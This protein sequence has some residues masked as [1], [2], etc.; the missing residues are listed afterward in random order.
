MNT[1]KYKLFVVIL[2]LF[3]STVEAQSVIQDWTGIPTPETFNVVTWNIEH[4]GREGQGPDDIEKQYANV[5]TVI[6]SLQADIIGLQEMYNIPLFEQLVEDLK[7]Y[8]GFITDYTASSLQVAFLYRID[9]IEFLDSRLL[10]AEFG[11]SDFD[12]NRRPPLEFTFRVKI[13]E[14]SDTMH[15]VTYHARHDTDNESYNRRLNASESLKAYFDEHR[16]GHALVF[17]GDFND[18]VIKAPRGFRYPPPYTPY[19]NFVED[20]SYAVVTKPLSYAGGMTHERGMMIDHIVVN[21]H[22][23]NLWMR[24]SEKVHLPFYIDDYFNTT[25]DHLPVIARFDLTGELEPQGERIVVVEPDNYPEEIGNLN[26]VIEEE[27]GRDPETIFELRRDVVY[28]TDRSIENNGFHLHLR[29]QKGSGKP[30]VIRPGINQSGTSDHLF[31][32]N[33]DV[34]FEGVFLVPVD[35]EGMLR[36]PLVHQSSGNTIRFLDGYIIGSYDI[37]FWFSCGSGNSL[38]I[39]NSIFANAGRNDSRNQGRFIDTRGYDQDTIWVEHSTIYN[40]QHSI[41]RNPGG[42]VN[43][44]HYNHNTIFNVAQY[45]RLGRVVHA[46]VTNNLMINLYTIGLHV[47]SNGGIIEFAP[48]GVL[49]MTEADRRFNIS[50]N[51]IGHVTDDVFEAML[52]ARIRNSARNMTKAPIVDEFF[53]SMKDPG[54]G[55]KITFRN[56]FEENVIFAD[57]PKSF[58]EWTEFWIDSGSNGNVVPADYP[59]GYDRWD[60]AAE[61]I[62]PSAYHY[63]IDLVRDFSYSSSHRSYTAAESGFPVGDLNWFPEQLDAWRFGRSPVNVSD[64]KAEIPEKFRLLGNYPNPFNPVTRIRYEI[65]ASTDAAIEVYDVTG[66]RVYS[67]ELGVLSPGRYDTALDL[68]DR[69]SGVYLVRLRAGS[70]VQ[71]MAITL[72]K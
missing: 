22:L 52:A 2:M 45:I 64:Q 66:R 37:M 4:F 29:S 43:Y 20:T 15:A 5:I 18:D 61:L 46:T 60:E 49:G 59:M 65:S 51:N 71:A 67:R 36:R 44:I 7:D 54:M 33:D 70:E 68:S 11:I 3:S 50:H 40:M 27:I 63:S 42:V 17:L 55:A 41:T 12:V 21:Q 48:L 26:R 16:S 53:L 72:V 39:A 38:F 31:Y 30:P 10:D 24:G 19:H 9:R 23:K 35:E 8:D 13:G 25:S 62:D 58:V 56:N 28:W 1:C 6:D 14:V 47:D 57:P 69:S 32:T 34:T